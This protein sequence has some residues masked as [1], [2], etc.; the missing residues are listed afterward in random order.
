[1]DIEFAERSLTLLLV[2]QIDAP[3]ASQVF[4]QASVRLRAFQVA[5][6][7]AIQRHHGSKQR[8][9]VN[10][11]IFVCRAEP[12]QSFLVDRCTV[13]STTPNWPAKI[14]RSEQRVLVGVLVRHAVL[15]ERLIDEL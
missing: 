4:N 9:E 2:G 14:L 3:V 10:Q 8:E 11:N 1:M 12:H 6:N 15:Q 5:E 13:E 7:V